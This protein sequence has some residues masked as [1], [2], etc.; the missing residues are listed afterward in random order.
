MR[1]GTDWG[2]WVPTGECGVLSAPLPVTPP[3]LTFRPLEGRSH[4]LALPVPDMIE[5]TM[6]ACLLFI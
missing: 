3:G 5:A 1:E 2:G 6:W 4:F